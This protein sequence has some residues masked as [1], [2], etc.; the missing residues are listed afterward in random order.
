[1]TI[2]D[3]IK[4]SQSLLQQLAS[5]QDVDSHAELKPLVAQLAEQIKSLSAEIENIPASS[6]QSTNKSTAPVIDEKTG[7]YQFENEQG[8]FCPN[9]Y[10]QTSSRV[11]TKR[12]N[13][14][15]RVCSA[16]HASIR[17]KN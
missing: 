13:R 11:N 3:S 10:D 5:H 17:P 7:C 1:M 14:K 16:C 8:F 15:L 12:L 2:T 9:C 4:N 6:Q